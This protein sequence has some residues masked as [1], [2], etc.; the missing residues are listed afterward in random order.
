MGRGDTR[1]TTLGSLLDYLWCG[2][3]YLPSL[4]G[5]H[6]RTVLGRVA[7]FATHWSA[8]RGDIR[9]MAAT[10]SKTL[11]LQRLEK[12]LAGVRDDF[13]DTSDPAF[14]KWKRDSEVAIRYVFGDGS[15]QL[16]ELSHVHY[17][18]TGVFP[19][20]RED[21]AA[22]HRGLERARSLLESMIDEVREYWEEHIALTGQPEVNSAAGGPRTDKAFIVHGRDNAARDAVARVMKQL[23]IDAVILSEQPSGGRTIIEKF[24]GE[25]D[26]GFAIVLLTP[27]DAGGLQDSDDGPKPRP[28][29]NVVFEMG[30]FVGRLGRGRVCALK[31]DDVDMEIPSDYAGV[32]YVPFGEGRD[33]R[34]ALAGELR[35]AGFKVD[36]NK[37]L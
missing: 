20:P 14:V 13:A 31:S 4:L 21:E 12:A 23:D 22:L 27:D 8:K 28:R 11:A 10:M 16:E 19:E 6:D 2:G 36:V 32:V 35:S 17:W 5:W 33:W 37:L 24:E 30:F 26:V 1:R 7:R 29:Q 25:A 34:L 18:A 15:R 9:G 3:K